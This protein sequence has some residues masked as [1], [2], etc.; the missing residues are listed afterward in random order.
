[1]RCDYCHNPSIVLS[2]GKLCFEQVKPFLE[3]RKGLLKAVVLSGGEPSLNKEI[4]EICEYLKSNGFKIKLDTNGLKPKLLKK[5]LDAKLLDFVALDFKATKEKFLKTTKQD[6][7]EEFIKSLKLLIKS[8]KDFE[9]RTTYHTSFLNLNDLKDILKVLKQHNFRNTFYIQKC[10]TSSSTL[11]KI[12]KNNPQKDFDKNFL[13]KYNF[14]IK[15]R[16]F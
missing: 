16:N 9:V 14:E 2:K 8:K 11:S 3:K 7:Y 12:P 4:F 6:G 5:L 13:D 15:Y 10:L 1:M